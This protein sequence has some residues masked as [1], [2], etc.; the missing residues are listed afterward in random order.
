MTGY[1][2]VSLNQV[3]LNAKSINGFDNIILT[4]PLASNSVKVYQNGDLRGSINI[5]GALGGGTLVL[6][7]G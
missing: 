2:T 4:R 1:G 3:G 7:Q 5:S 6:G